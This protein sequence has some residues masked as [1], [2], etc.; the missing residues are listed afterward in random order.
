MISNTLAATA[1]SN[2]VIE[3]YVNKEFCTTSLKSFIFYVD[4]EVKSVLVPV[5][6]SESRSSFIYTLSIKDFHFEP[7][8]K[9]ELVTEH[10][11]FIPIDFSFLALTK[12]FDEKYRYDGK[13]G[14]IYSKRSTKFNLFAP[15]ATRV[16]LILKRKGSDKEETF[17]LEHN[18]DN[19]VFSI[20]VTGDLDEASYLYEV[21]V[22]SLVRKVV[23][24]YAYSLS[25]NSRIAYVIDPKRVKEI[26]THRRKLPPFDD[27]TKAIIY[28]CSV[29]DMTSL[30]KVE[31]AMTYDALSKEGY[32]TKNG[33]PIGLDYLSSLGVSHIQLMPVLDFQT[34]ND[35]KPKD[36]YNWG[37]DPMF[38]FAPEG[39]YSKNPN[40]PYS[41]VLGL[42]KLVSQ[43]HSKGMRVVLDVV[44]NHV[45]SRIGNALS[46]IVPKYYYRY[47]N[48][49]YPS[50]GSGCGD[51]I[52]SRRYM[53][54]KLIIDSMLHLVDFYDVDGFRF[55]L[56][57]ILDVDTVNMGYEAVKKVRPDLMYYGEGWDL[58]TDLPSDKKA[59]YYNSAKMPSVGFFNDR[60]RD[61]A[62]GKSSSSELSVR[63]YLLGDFNYV[64]GFKHVMSGSS[65][66]IAFPPLLS[67]YRQS[68]NYVECHDNHTVY[69]KI[70]ASCFDDKEKEILNRI[71]MLDISTLFAC[72]IPFFHQGQEI[73]HSKKGNGNTYNAGD[74]LNGFDYSLLE[75]RKDMYEFFKDAI[76]LKK[77]FIQLSGKH[78]DDLAS[79]MSFE[80]ISGGLLIKYDLPKCYFYIIFNPSKNTIMYDFNEYTSLVFNEAGFIEDCHF[81]IRLGI[82]N[83]LSVNAYLQVKPGFVSDIEEGKK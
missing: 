52:E 56:M 27:V 76:K 54:R 12:E 9:Y 25:S 72:G 18:F 63:G 59:S 1:K 77:Y 4:G 36:S 64:D 44:Y 17:V 43:L 29:R 28:E 41:R 21:E 46:L 73:G 50:N 68:I 61:V 66:P 83:A 3:V 38:Y 31:D 37:Y 70:K 78:Y 7:G 42:R 69:D 62:K 15:F 79:H 53:V 32:R 82:I 20:S 16:V 13:L 57:G 39:S 58:W 35:D 51:D 81:Y 30:T 47:N 67:S 49:G 40:D 6:K 24:P 48:D 65:L 75:K 80:N 45:Y 71:K 14:V 19:G 23:D 26:N 22:F 8:H 33:Y 34:V 10:N 74:D 60:Y 11:Y 2:K 5:S 55:D